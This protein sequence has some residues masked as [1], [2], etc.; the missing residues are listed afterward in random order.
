M[1]NRVG[2]LFVVAGLLPGMLGLSS[3]AAAVAAPD[4]SVHT[5]LT[6]TVALSPSDAWTV[7]WFGIGTSVANSE[8][9][10]WN[11]TKWVSVKTAPEGLTVNG[12]EGVSA[13]GPSDVWAVGWLVSNCLIEH[14]NGQKWAAVKCPYK[15]VLSQLNGVDARTAADAWAVGYVT[16]NSN[17]LGLSEHWNG[18]N[19]TQVTTAKVSGLFVTL[20]SVLVLAPD[21]VLAVGSYETK[22]HGTYVRHELAEHWNGTAWQRVGVPS[23]STASY[24]MSVSGSTSAGVIAVG[25]VSAG[26]HSVPLIE[27]WNGTKFVQVKQP[28]SSGDLGGVTV[29]GRTGAYAAG[30]TGSGTTLV[31]HYDGKQ[32]T[33]VP[34]PNP[35]DGGYLSSIAA[36]SASFVVAAGWHGPDPNE[37]PLIEQGNG[38]TWHITRE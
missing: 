13:T 25:A 29:L 34:T 18:H 22:S 38:K 3:K 28:V 31:E 36:P 33:Q 8:S 14:Y 10:H 35:S 21:S 32:W 9:L 5:F 30:E 11:G 19:W 37:R 26:G 12:L 6:G 20:N 24:L 27:S 7:G 1:R 23:F 15:G 16:P 4:D 17:Q 2:A